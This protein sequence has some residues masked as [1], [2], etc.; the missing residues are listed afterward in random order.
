MV[1]MYLLVMAITSY[2][3]FRFTRSPLLPVLTCSPR[4]KIGC[5]DST[6][7]GK[8][9]I[10]YQISKSAFCNL[11]Q[12]AGLRLRRMMTLV[13]C[14]ANWLVTIIRLLKMPASQLSLILEVI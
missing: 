14:C 10:K 7:L 6:S 11:Q 3:L 12:A 9:G 2:S 8:G 4:P 13:Q 5:D 1:T